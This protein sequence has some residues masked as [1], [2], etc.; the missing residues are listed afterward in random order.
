MPVST[1][2]RLTE[3][4]E[5]YASGAALSDYLWFTVFGG[6]TPTATNAITCVTGTKSAK[7]S[8]TAASQRAALKF[9]A[10]RS[11]DTCMARAR[12]YFGSSLANGFTFVGASETPFNALRPFGSTKWGYYLFATADQTS[13]YLFAS[14]LTADPLISEPDVSSRLGILQCGRW[15]QFHV[16][17]NRQLNE[18]TL[19]VD[20]VCIHKQQ[21]TTANALVSWSPQEFRIGIDSMTTYLDDVDLVIEP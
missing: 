16:S 21:L 17:I 12:I 5:G 6:A 11:G 20:G 19:V 3:D 7:L 9:T 14:H 10:S 2:T 13:M 18:A 1:Y 15:Y 4:F 8:A